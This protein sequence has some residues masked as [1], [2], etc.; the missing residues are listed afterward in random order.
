MTATKV[1]LTGGGFQDSEGNLLV[2]GY[3]EFYLSQD[4]SVTGVGNICAGIAV[5]I[6]LDSMGNAASSTSTPTAADQFI[7]GND[8]LNTP[9]TFYKVI[10]YTAEGQPAWGPNNQQVV[11]SSPFDLGTWVPNTV[12]SWTPPVQQVSL[13]VNGTPASSQIR[14]NLESTDSSITITDLGN[15]NIDLQGSSGFAAGSNIFG[16]PRFNDQGGGITNF[17]LVA[18]IPAALVA[19]TGTS[20]VLSLFTG[21]NFGGT[22]FEYGNIVIAATAASRFIGGVGSPNYAWTTAPT[23]ITF[24]TLSTPATMYSSSPVSITIDTEHDYYLMAYIEGTNSSNIPLVNFSSN[25]PVVFQ[26]LFGFISGDHTGDADASGLQ[27]LSGSGNLYLY[28]S[29]TVG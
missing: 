7:W 24:P 26:E 23:P 27:S 21:S 8:S 29:L 20:A 18:I 17:T 6:Q 11:G 1:Q 2:D 10:G 13:N 25:I 9:N 16:F 12:F 14:Q 22:G 3:L 4:S 19:A 15:G 5:K 28:T